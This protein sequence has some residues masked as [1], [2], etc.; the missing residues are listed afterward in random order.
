MPGYWLRYC[1]AFVSSAFSFGGL[2]GFRS[3]GLLLG[4][5][6]LGGG[7]KDGKF[8]QPVLCRLV[9]GDD[10]DFGIEVRVRVTGD[11]MSC[12]VYSLP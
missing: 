6:Q 2:G 8:C 11:L 3:G 10:E 7:D 1:S 4:L 9:A 12:K 5:V